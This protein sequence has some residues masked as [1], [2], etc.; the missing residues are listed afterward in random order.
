MA[1]LQIETDDVHKVM[2]FLADVVRGYLTQ[3]TGEKKF[4]GNIII[5]LNCMDGAIGNV[6]TTVKKNYNKNDMV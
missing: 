1:D 6:S 2:I 3:C 4:K 5:E